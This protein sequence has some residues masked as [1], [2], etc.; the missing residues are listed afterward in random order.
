MGEEY[1]YRTIKYIAFNPISAGIAQKIKESSFTL[2]SLLLNGSE[3]PLCAHKSILIKQYDIETL[4]EYLNEPLSDKEI[5]TL[6]QERKRKIEV[7]DHCVKSEE[8]KELHH[9]FDSSMSKERRNQAIYE[10][11]MDGHT[12]RSISKK[13]GL[14]DAMISIVVKKF[15]I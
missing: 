9:Y 8:K 6:T 15:K 4:A 3:V 13:L 5:A 14:S 10:A 11:Y 7:E 1:L 12:Q 2:S